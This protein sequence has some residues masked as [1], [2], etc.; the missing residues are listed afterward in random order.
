MVPARPM[1][2]DPP[3]ISPDPLPAARHALRAL[4][5]RARGEPELRREALRLLDAARRDLAPPRREPAEAPERLPARL[6]A[7]RC[8]VKAEAL[9]WQGRRR[10]L[11]E[12]GDR[13]AVAEGDR[14]TT[15][16]ARGL[17]DCFL[18]MCREEYHELETHAELARVAACYRA[19]ADAAEAL[20]L[21]E[22]RGGDGAVRPAF[23]LLGE[24]QSALRVAVERAGWRRGDPDQA[25][26]F[27]WLR[28]ETRARNVYV[29]HMQLRSPADP[30]AAPAIAARTAALLIELE[31]PAES[32]RVAAE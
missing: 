14:R 23:L 2:P 19:V 16:A 8:R 5:E 24:A 30:A 22:R 26:I 20:E 18:W 17:P 32:A 10:A 13:E 3:T 15:E 9:L 1:I 25:L 29:P 4:A 27:A 12:G 21:A 7:A 28:R 31:A 11:A 6:I